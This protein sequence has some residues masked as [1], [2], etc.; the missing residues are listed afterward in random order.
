MKHRSQ[1][2]PESPASSERLPGQPSSTEIR[3]VGAT[4]PHE[5]ILAD[6]S[7]GVVLD[8]GA[9]RSTPQIEAALAQVFTTLDDPELSV[10]NRVKHIVSGLMAWQL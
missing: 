1:T 6:M 4:A 3:P 2:R 9:R 8:N 10:A 7:A 5:A